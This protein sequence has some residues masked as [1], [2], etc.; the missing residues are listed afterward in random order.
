MDSG[1]YTFLFIFKGIVIG[2]VVG[3]AF[4][5]KLKRVKL[6]FEDDEIVHEDLMRSFS[7]KTTW[8]EMRIKMKKIIHSVKG[9]C[10]DLFKK[11]L[12]SVLPIILVTFS[13]EYFYYRHFFVLLVGK[14]AILGLLIVMWRCTLNFLRI[15]PKQ[16][17]ATFSLLKIKNSIFKCAMFGSLNLVLYA[18]TVMSLFVTSTVWVCNRVY[19]ADNYTTSEYTQAFKILFTFSIFTGILSFAF[20]ITSMSYSNSSLISSSLISGIKFSLEPD[21]FRDP[22]AFSKFAG[23]IFSDITTSAS[24]CYFTMTTLTFSGLALFSTSPQLAI[25][26]TSMY[27]PLLLYP[28]SIF[29]LIPTFFVVFLPFTLKKNK[30]ILLSVKIFSLVYSL[31]VC[32]SLMLFCQ[33]LLPDYFEFIQNEQVVVIKNKVA[34]SCI[35]AGNLL[36]LI[37]ALIFENGSYV[38]KK[39]V[40]EVVESCKTGEGTGVILGLAFGYRACIMTFI[41][42]SVVVSWGYYLAGLFGVWFLAAG[43]C[44]NLPLAH[45]YQFSNAFLHHSKCLCSFMHFSSQITQK[46]ESIMGITQKC[47][48]FSEGF[49]LVS[50]YLVNLSVFYV[51]AGIKIKNDL[52]LLNPTV[53]CGIFTGCMIPY[54]FAA[55]N[56]LMTLHKVKNLASEVEKQCLNIGKFN[57][58]LA[59][60]ASVQNI[61]KANLKKSGF[62]LTLFTISLFLTIKYLFGSFFVS[63]LFIGVFISSFLI[64]VASLNSSFVWTECRNWF[65]WFS[66]PLESSCKSIGISVDVVGTLLKESNGA[67]A[68]VVLEL[69]SVLLVLL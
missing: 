34:W 52:N 4:L 65:G 16:V 24:R 9:E 47:E 37:F 27:F 68:R 55:I 31:T 21:D 1:I 63:A 62:L 58:Y 57:E 46:I 36:G 29:L 11:T 49:K 39:N 48:I 67:A 60:F 33:S 13:L 66:D 53:F 30:S 6:E 43:S 2:L 15:L 54:S 40:A 50:T 51:F 26:S 45:L 20:K 35:V 44:L 41:L 59:D 3:T 18:L 22:V 14:F 38:N 10:S 69:L 56:T 8:K 12:W 17:L 28:I 19:M 61:I 7:N 64:E 42:F 32:G 23:K 5:C 25:S